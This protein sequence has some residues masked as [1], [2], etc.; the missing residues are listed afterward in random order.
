MKRNFDIFSFGH[1]SL[2]V[3]KT[4][5]KKFEALG[6]AILHAAWVAYQLGYKNGVLTKSTQADK[7]RL[8]EFPPMPKEDLFW[9]ESPTTTSILNDYK[10]KTL[11]RRDCSSQGQAAPYTKG[12][13]P[14]FSAKIVQY[15]ALMHGEVDLDLIKWLS[16]RGKLVTDAAGFIRK[17]MPD[18]TMQSK[19]WPDLKAAFPCFDYFKADA[20]EAKF[21]T[22]LECET[23]DDRVKATSRFLEWGAKEIILSHNQELIAATK[24]GCWAAPFKNR[25]LSGRTG[26]GDT[27]TTA[28]VLARLESKPADAVKFAAALT[29]LKMETPGPFKGKRADVEAYLKQ[30]Y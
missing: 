27:A 24:D 23:H 10:D 18:K 11:E 30:F 22:G 7:G 15:S 25:N 26:R 12:D 21:L 20:A 13:F 8:S 16:K 28:Y 17:V 6:G 9:V 2:D 14:D 3:I 4:P 1:I 19:P 29:S 5:D